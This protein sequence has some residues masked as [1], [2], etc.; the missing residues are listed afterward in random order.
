MAKAGFRRLHVAIAL[1]IAQVSPALAQDAGPAGQ[2]TMANGVLLRDGRPWAMKGVKL[3]GRVTPQSALDNGTVGHAIHVAHSRFG[4]QLPAR[5]KAFGADT[6]SIEVSQYGLDPGHPVHDPAY[7]A[8]VVDAIR[9]FRAAGLTVIICMQWERAAGVRGDAG[10]PGQ[11]TGNAWAA[12]LPMLSKDDAG[13]ILDLF[14]EPAGMPGPA[15]FATWQAAH[16]ALVAHVRHAGFHRQIVVVSG[17]RGA[18]WLNGTP[19]ITDPDHRV[20][21]GIHPQLSVSQFHFDSAAG[22]DAAFGNFCLQHACLATEWTLARRPDEPLRTGCGGNAPELAK[23]LLNY[24]WQRRMG[25]V[26][27]SFDFPGTLFQADAPQTATTFATWAGT[28][29]ASQQP[30]GNG[31]LLTDWF[32]THR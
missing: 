1:L 30:Y 16:N 2:I 12:L 14:N 9:M 6:V 28:C 32:H 15:T 11:T 27:W 23:T 10:V 13:L 5:I 26:G 8:Q 7:G 25:V 18:E 20:V 31:Q 19:P 22:W 21:F 17:L 4:P 24:L 3:V 29:E